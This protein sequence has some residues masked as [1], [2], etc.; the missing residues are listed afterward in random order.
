MKDAINTMLER[1][2]MQTGTLTTDNVANKYE[3]K[4]KVHE[5]YL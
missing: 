3:G 2:Q 4:S 1:F 5:I